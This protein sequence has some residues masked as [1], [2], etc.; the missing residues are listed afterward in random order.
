MFS[1]ALTSSPD[2]YHR[3]TQTLLSYHAETLV[4]VEASVQVCCVREARDIVSTK[5]TTRTQGLAWRL[6]LE[7]CRLRKGRSAFGNTPQAVLVGGPTLSMSR[8]CR[9]G[10]VETAVETPVGTVNQH[11]PLECTTHD[12]VLVN[13]FSNVLT[14]STCCLDLTFCALTCVEGRSCARLLRV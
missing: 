11:K 5:Y 7:P 13:M 10:A 6:L 12:A 8:S 4:C 14:S 3:I 9:P 2:L 1:H